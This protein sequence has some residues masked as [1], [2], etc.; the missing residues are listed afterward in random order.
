MSY[1][2]KLAVYCKTLPTFLVIVAYFVI[3]ICW[4]LKILEIK[5]P[6]GKP[7][8]YWKNQSNNNVIHMHYTYT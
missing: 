3:N 6:I 8:K 2:I 5:I 4:L 1:L 7:L